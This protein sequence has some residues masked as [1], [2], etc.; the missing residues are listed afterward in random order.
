MDDAPRDD[1][2]LPRTGARD[3]LQIA[4][5][6]VDGAFLFGSKLH[7]LLLRGD[8]AIVDAGPTPASAAISNMRLRRNGS[9]TRLPF[10]QT[11]TVLNDTPMW[12]A[13]CSC[14]SPWCSRSE[15]T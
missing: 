8:A 3:K 4:S 9:G 5:R 6:M 12:C 10:S 1:L 15:R 2:G 11:F 7:R 13:N 14:V